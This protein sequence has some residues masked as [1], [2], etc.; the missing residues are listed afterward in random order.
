MGFAI[1]QTRALNPGALVN[2]GQRQV[3][4]HSR[5]RHFAHTHQLVF[6][7][8]LG[9]AGA[10]LEVVHHAFGLTGRARGVGD[11]REISACTRNAAR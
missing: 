8:A 1:D 3:R 7:D 10:T 9:G 6:D 4:Q 5:I 2:V 11:K